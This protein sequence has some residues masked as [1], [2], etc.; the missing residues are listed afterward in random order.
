[1]YREAKLLYVASNAKRS[2][3]RLVYAIEESMGYYNLFMNPNMI[4]EVS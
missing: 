4:S 3:N 2:K 1:M